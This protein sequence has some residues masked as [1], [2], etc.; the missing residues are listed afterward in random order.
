MTLRRLGLNLLFLVPGEVGGSE[1]MSRRLVAALA[2]LR[3]GLE[4]VVYCG[5]EA[6][7]ALAAEPW[8][9]RARLVCAPRPSRS[10]AQRVVV[11]QTWLP[12]RLRRDRV[13]LLHS[14][15]TT[16]PVA[17]PVPGVVS[18]LDLIYHHFPETFPAASRL[19]LRLL[20]PAGARRARRVI[21]ISESGRQDIVRTL[22]IDP[23]KVDVVHLGYGMAESPE[24]VPERVL[25]ERHGLGNRPVVL[26]V[27][28]ALRHKNLERLLEAF[29]AVRADPEP[30]LVLVGHAGRDAN[31]LRDVAAR[32]GVA[33][34]VRFAGW[35]DDAE[36]E[37]LYRTAV[38]F[39]YP[40][41]LEGFG[42]PVLEA[43]RRGV[44]V[45][46]SGT[47]ALPEV[48]GNAAEYFDPLDVPSIAAAL[49]RLLGDSHR[50]GVLVRRGNDRVRAFTWEKTAR[51]TL[52]VYERALGR[53]ATA[54]S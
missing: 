49:T 15:G 40:S 5:P 14:L 23:A 52:G 28:A 22:G 19:G 18:V 31:R 41:L 16:A 54:T 50:R 48:A 12:A 1:I 51:E 3:P 39:A 8:G 30:V 35:I 27:S 26:T 42:L 13:Q 36:L 34:R 21:A 17:T 6:R 29:A 11:E 44:A 32:A 20:V 33:E 45:A 37:G 9:T 24:L 53:D 25:R 7:E 46:C 38:V 43:M 10:K 47:S 2:E 4:L